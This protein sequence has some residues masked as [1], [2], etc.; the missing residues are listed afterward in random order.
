[1]EI[2]QSINKAP[3]FMITCYDVINIDS[4]ATISEIKFAC[5]KL[6]LKHWQKSQ[7]FHFQFNFAALDFR[8]ISLS[9]QIHFQEKGVKVVL[10]GRY[11]RE[12]KV[13]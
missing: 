11:E 8:N 12:L 5:K 4:Y 1:M 6:T 10:H 13:L 7:L 2:S 3:G 9:G